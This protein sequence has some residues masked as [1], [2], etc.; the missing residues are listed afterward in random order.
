[1]T[2]E[3]AKNFDWNKIV[4]ELG[5]LPSQKIHCSILAVEGLKKVIAEYE[6]KGKKK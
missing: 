3:E 4:K 2:L 5:G 1:M 6:K